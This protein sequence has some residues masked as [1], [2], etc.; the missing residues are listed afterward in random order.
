GLSDIVL[1][2][3]WA[4]V[5]EQDCSLT[6]Q[7]RTFFPSGDSRLGLGTGHFSIEPGLLYYRRMD[8]VSFP[9][10]FKGWIPLGRTTNTVDGRNFAGSVLTYGGGFGYDVIQRQNLRVMPLV[11][12]V[13]WSVLDGLESVFS[14]DHSPLPF[15]RTVVVPQDH[16]AQR[17]GV[18]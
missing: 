16:G 11:E 1:G 18:T 7:L 15:T 12:I 4:V 13:G 8:R 9:S 10:E 14:I 5:A 6:V 17:A 3:K 2:A